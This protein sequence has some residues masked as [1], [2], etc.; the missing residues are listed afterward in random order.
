MTLP[1][2]D[3]RRRTRSVALAV[4]VGSALE[5]FDFYL[6]ASMAALVFPRLF[7]PDYDPSVAA[8]ASIATFAVGFVARP[9]GA[10]FF[11]LLADRVGRRR[12]LAITFLLMGVASGLVGVIPTYAAIGVAAPV[13]LVVLRV[14]QG[15][16]AGAEFGGA[17]AVAYEHAGVKT[18]GRLGSWPAL[19]VNIGLFASALC[20]TVLTSLPD[21]ALYGWAWRVPFIASFALVALGFWVRR[22]M[23]ESPEFEQVAARTQHA[24]PLRDL[25]RHDWRGLVVVMVMTVGYLGSSYVFKTFSLTYLST[26]RDVPANVGAFG[27]T[28]AS[29]VAIGIVP[30]AGRLCDRIG[31]G[32]VMRIGAAGVLLLAFPFF[33]LLDTEEP[34]LI[35]LA[36]ILST[37]CFIPMM[38][39]ASGSYYAQQ[40]PT[41]V[42]T[43]GVGTG[44]EVGG[45]AGGL[46]PL[47]AISLITTAPGNATW[48]VS[49]LFVV[50]AVLIVL[51]TV[52]DQ[53][54]RAAA[55]TVVL[56]AP[57]RA[58][59]EADAAPVARRA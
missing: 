8:L 35:W 38:L 3:S 11:G 18:R 54:A 9:F 46:A 37:G 53:H 24:T 39:A 20:V 52:W 19:G 55:R 5:W 41:E 7:F 16:G 43:S 31:S 33:W 50:S 36:L 1:A 10:L 6:F 15:I 48:S 58:G 28:L 44:R 23:P 4:I 29:G 27:V 22:Q 47:A 56:D 57:P 21:S 13:A 51:G 34:V 45:V 40:F 49:L 17:I 14:C 2:T 25:F 26:F 59:L 42:R 32:S 12:V 30:L